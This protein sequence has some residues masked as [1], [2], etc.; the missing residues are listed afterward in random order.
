MTRALIH[1]RSAALCAAFAFA[2]LAAA[3]EKPSPPPPGPTPGDDGGSVVT[4]M[5]AVPTTH[6][7]F[8]RF[9]GTGSPNDC[10]ADADCHSAGCGGEVCSADAG[11]VTTCEVLPVSLPE[12]TACGCVEGQCQW[13]NADGITLPPLPEPAPEASCAT[14][15]CQ[16]PRQ[17]LEYFGIAGPSGPKFVSCEIPCIS[18]LTS[19]PASRSAATK[20]EAACPTGMSC[21]TIADGPGSVCR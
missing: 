3:C 12:N 4:R 11:V 17:C 6:P 10:S 21:I 7:L 14:V 19:N 5:P 20:Q 9:E 15:R 16:A 13:W 8:D 18:D 1:R 2:A